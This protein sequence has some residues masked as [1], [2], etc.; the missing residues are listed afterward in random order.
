MNDMLAAIQR[1]LPDTDKSRYDIAYERGRAQARS[2]L[3]LG[4]LTIG[5]IA[6][7]AATFFLDPDRGD[8]RRTAFAEQVGATW[9]RTQAMATERLQ[10]RSY[11]VSDDAKRTHDVGTTSSL[12]TDAAGSTSGRTSGTDAAAWA[13][14][15]AEDAIA[16]DR[17]AEGQAADVGAAATGSGQTSEPD[18]WPATKPVDDRETEKVAG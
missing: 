13:T 2:S 15:G 1:E 9:N 7:A 12:T 6:G 10:R 5:A 8:R 4:G 17:S 14:P 11:A 18:A 16:I 3:F